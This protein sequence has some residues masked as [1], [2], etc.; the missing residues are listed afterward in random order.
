MKQSITT[1]KKINLTY[2]ES[3][4]SFEFAALIYNNP[5][6]NQYA[7]QMVGFDKDWVYSGSRRN[8]TYTNLDPGDYT[9]RVKGSN[10]DGIWNEGGT[11]IKISI[12]PPWWQT[13]WFK[14]C[15]AALIFMTI[16][17]GFRK[18]FNKLKK[19][20][21]AQEEF[22]RKLL[23]S[24]ETERKRIANELHDSIA[25]DILVLK[26]N[27][28]LAMQD[29]KDEK[30]KSALNE[31]SEQS[32]STLNDV[33]SISYNL[34]PHQ[35]EALGLTKAVKSMVDKVSKSSDIK[36]IFEEDV[37]DNLF[38]EENEVYIFRIL[39]EAINNIIKHSSATESLIKILRREN[40]VSILISDNGKG[41]S[42]NKDVN[43]N[44]L[45]LSGISERVK[46]LGGTM[47]IESEE[48]DG[49]R[50]KIDLPTLPRR[51]V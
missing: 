39:Q 11:S 24:Q 13:W 20:K 37:I 42:L 17:F 4:F 27:A 5:S 48:G 29:T 18:R 32:T 47:N 49:T 43:K 14:S 3:V 33:R 25:H 51:A 30:T 40:S 19:E 34:H 46:M 36:F 6:K 21:E 35:I 44:S 7:Y 38:S 12:T 31:I 8:V 9:F 28:M 1:A 10:N 2:K 26:N 16:G 41:F 15:G 22:S 50:V 23:A 45:G